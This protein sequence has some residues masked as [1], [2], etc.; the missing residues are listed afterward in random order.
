MNTDIHSNPPK[1][2]LPEA[3]G[4]M[5]RQAAEGARDTYQKVS[6][7]VE[8]GADLTRD[9]AQHAVATAKDAAYCATDSAKDLYQS[10]AV[11][12]KDALATSRDC[13]R[14][15]PVPFVLGAIAF[16][17]AMGYLIVSARRKPTF[18][19]RYAEE[20]L[21][22]MRETILAA[23]APVTQRVH[24]GYDS[25]RDSAGKAMDRMHRSDAGRTAH[26]LS[27]QIGRISSN[28]KFW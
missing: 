23:L 10:A 28:L 11:N 20:P 24:D 15:N 5:I 1:N 25:A 12:A 8:E 17:A 22:T 4:E 21:A 9:F 14:R 19:E 3:T 6:S 27:D 18:S 2:P 7:K 26:S 16:G 13:V